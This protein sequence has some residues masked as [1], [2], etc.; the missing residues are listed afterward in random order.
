MPR[1]LSPFLSL[2]H[3]SALCPRTVPGNTPTLPPT[4]S[5]SYS[6]VSCA[7]FPAPSRWW[8]SPRTDSSALLPLPHIRSPWDTH[9]CLLCSHCHLQRCHFLCSFLPC[10]LTHH[11]K[12]II[13]QGRPT[14]S[15]P[16]SESQPEFSGWIVC[17][18]PQSCSCLVWLSLNVISSPKHISFILVSPLTAISHDI[19]RPRTW[20][21]SPF[22]TPVLVMDL[23]TDFRDSIHLWENSAENLISCLT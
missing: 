14:G 1:L 20:T 17:H 18:C 13:N 16:H 2:G 3:C 19:I 15:L 22:V 7:H 21:P 4:L 9:H 23:V 6:S 10:M 5:A 8:I 11:M 12:V